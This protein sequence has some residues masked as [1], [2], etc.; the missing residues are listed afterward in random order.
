[1]STTGAQAE[2]A[3]H[4]GALREALLT[5]AAEVIEDRGIEALTLRGLARDL[6]VSHGAP[7]RHFPSREDLLATLA[8]TAWAQ[9]RE[10]TLSKADA[11]GDDPWV[12][13]NA[14]GRGYLTWAIEN[15]ALFTVI[16]HPD[17]NRFAD[18]ALLEATRQFQ[19]TVREA[20]LATQ[21]TGR[22]PEV[23][24]DVLT[25]YTNAVPFGAA[26]IFNNPT[27]TRELAN[28]D[29]DQLVADVVELVV[30]VRQR[31]S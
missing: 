6:G 8:A 13:L 24:P 20:V 26:M 19:Q 4:H 1:M 22:H 12:R 2:S 7:N 27:F 30:P 5:R 16:T 17:V 11:A 9:A 3:Y 21:A 31:I 25:L 29:I 23:D 10:A 28:R 14:M 15:R 18:E